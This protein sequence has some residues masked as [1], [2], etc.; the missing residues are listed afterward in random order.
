MGAGENPARNPWLGPL[1]ADQVCYVVHDAD[2]PG[3]QGALKTPRRNGGFRPGWAMAAAETA[4]EVRNVELPYAVVESH[5]KDL[6]DWIN[7]GHT[8]ADL[9]A[10]AETGPLVEPPAAPPLRPISTAAASFDPLEEACR[11]DLGVAK[12]FAAEH[13]D[14]VRWCDQWS[15]WLV[16][17]GMRWQIDHARGVEALAK[18]TAESIWREIDAQ[19][20]KVAES[21]GSMLMRFGHKT[22]SARGLSNILTLARS[23]QGVPIQ[24]GE[25]NRQPWLFNCAN[26][27]IDLQTGEIKPHDSA[28]YLTVVCNRSYD[29]AAECP[30]WE[31]SMDDIFGDDREMVEYVQRQLGYALVGKVF[32]HILPIWW[33]NGSNGKSLIVETLLHVLGDE[34]ATK[35]PRDLLLARGGDHHP[36]ELADLHGRRLVVASETDEGRKLAEGLVKEITGGDTIKARRMRED[37]WSFEPS[38]TVIM[39]TNHK[40][41]VKGTDNGIW[42]RL[43]LVPFTEKF[44]DPAKGEHGDER[45]RAD[46]RLAEKLQAEAVGILAWLVR[47]CIAWQRVG[48]NE[49]VDVRNATA[50]YRNEQDIIGDFLEEQ[51]LIGSAY[52]I[53]AS[54]I[55]SAYATWCE[56]RG[57]YPKT[58]RAFGQ[59]MTERNFSR[60]KSGPIWYEGVALRENNYENSDDDF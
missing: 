56:E 45:Y 28:D 34:Y 52:R 59:A 25:L 15:K 41:V 20:H 44:W 19:V 1:V 32:E 31:S 6:R 42:R 14:L 39:L 47:G 24:P 23:E 51:C 38:H 16:W 37:F 43:R 18:E 46:E 33:G 7:E 26:G 8:Y 5:G 53:K 9:L 30:L 36:T 3:Q 4:S 35:A 22:A 48:M 27:T 58:G 13:R 17:D 50:E 12:L 54:A 60:V 29:P 40:P 49:P 21:V 2:Q 10:L 11:T 57:E 55:Y